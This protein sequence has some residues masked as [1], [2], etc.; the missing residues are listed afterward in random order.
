MKNF[1]TSSF[2]SQTF[3]LEK[4][5]RDVYHESKT[6]KNYMHEVLDGCSKLS[7]AIFQKKTEVMK[8]ISEKQKLRIEDDLSDFFSQ[9]G[10]I[11]FEKSNLNE[12]V[13]PYKIVREKQQLFQIIKLIDE[14]KRGYFD[15]IES[16]LDALTNGNLVDAEILS[17]V[18]LNFHKNYR[19]EGNNPNRVI[20]VEF[21]EIDDVR[22]NRILTYKDQF[23][24]II[25]AN[26]N[27]GQKETNNLSISLAVDALSILDKQ[28]LAIESFLENSQIFSSFN[29]DDLVFDDKNMVNLDFFD[30]TGP[31]FRLVEEIKNAYSEEFSDL[32]T[33]FSNNTQALNMIHQK[34]LK[35]ILAKALDKFL[36]NCDHIEFLPAL[37][38]SYV[39][40]RTLQDFIK[41]INESV[42]FQVR[43]IFDPHL[44]NISKK[45]NAAIDEIISLRNKRDGTL[46]KKYRLMNT[47]LID[48][49]EEDTKELFLKFLMLYDYFE[50]RNE[51]FKYDP[52][53]YF[54]IKKH[55][56]HSIERAV[57]QN[58]NFYSL[59]TFEKLNEYYFI[60]KK[61]GLESKEI[62]DKLELIF[63]NYISDRHREIRVTFL[64]DKSSYEEYTE[65]SQNTTLIQ[66]FDLM[67]KTEYKKIKKHMKGSNGDY[68]LRNI[69]AKMDSELR[70]HILKLSLTI[71]Q[72]QK[73]RSDIKDL[74][75][76]M[77]K[78]KITETPFNTLKEKIKLVSSPK[79]T[80]KLFISPQDNLSDVKK[81]LKV[82]KD[83]QSVKEALEVIN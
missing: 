65:D 36:S 19:T 17:Y 4:M 2:K 64:Q 42:N 46:R 14:I 15:K 20:E 54:S 69:I 72:G 13:E 73:I 6:N 31:F 34:L 77:R 79:E 51:T 59:H 27:R 45:E 70:K 71:T 3:N 41:K 62:K 53:D 76:S 16:I 5:V 83:Y 22:M 8:K 47:D 68:L 52:E 82:R 74:R 49:Q 21:G 9:H 7:D 12:V 50:Q 23:V 80:V 37:Y 10:K 58:A 11:N 61:L 56:I 18:F 44:M 63:T 48:I 67:V 32:N 40:L 38:H 25:L 55:F 1:N 39:H 28:D 24:K 75:R 78:L 43:D 57:L 33:C 35:D 26:L 29:L 81:W 60:L 30:C 66:R